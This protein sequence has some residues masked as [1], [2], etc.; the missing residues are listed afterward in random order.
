MDRLQHIPKRA[1]DIATHGV[2]QGA[3]AAAAVAQTCTGHKLLLLDSV[4]PEE[5]GQA[6]FDELILQ[7]NVAIDTI[8]NEVSADM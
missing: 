2:R 8:G 1:R 6:G 4:F 3:A 7:F 5:D